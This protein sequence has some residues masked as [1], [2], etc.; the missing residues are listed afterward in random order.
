MIVK[1]FKKT[2]H[3]KLENLNED[4]IEN[5]DLFWND[6]YVQSSDGWTYLLDTARNEVC[7]VDNYGFDLFS[8][9]R[10]GKTV[11][12]YYIENNPEYEFNK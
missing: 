7:M 2:L 6:L 11:V 12:F 8:E 3:L 10:T 9:L 1:K 5:E 4:I